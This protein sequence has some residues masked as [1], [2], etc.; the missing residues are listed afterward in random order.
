MERG[1]GAP[2]TRSTSRGIDPS[3]V[4]TIIPPKLILSS[5]CGS[6]LPSKDNE[7]CRE[8]SEPNNP[9]LIAAMYIREGTGQSCICNEACGNCQKE[10]LHIPI[11]APS[12]KNPQRDQKQE[13]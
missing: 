8:R 3:N 6:K 10:R 5:S 4:R 7:E 1:W 9:A 11:L 2:C 13:T 12:G